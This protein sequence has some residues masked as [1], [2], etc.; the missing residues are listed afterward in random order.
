MEYLRALN[1]NGLAVGDY[2]PQ[3]PK[4][5]LLGDLRRLER[6]TQ[7]PRHI[8]EY[9]RVSGATEE[10]VRRIFRHFFSVPEPGCVECDKATEYAEKNGQPPRRCQYHSYQIVADIRGS[11]DWDCV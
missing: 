8:A 2:D 3:N 4:G 6:D 9:V 11:R 5:L 10:Q 1:R 7:N